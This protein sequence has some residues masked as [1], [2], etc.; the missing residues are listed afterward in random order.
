MFETN[1]AGNEV[2]CGVPRVAYCFR[3][4]PTLLGNCVSQLDTAAQ[5]RAPSSSHVLF[6]LGSR[7]APARCRAH[8]RQRRSGTGST[9]DVQA[10]AMNEPQGDAER[11][12]C[13]GARRYDAQPQIRIRE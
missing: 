8:Q 3:F 4:S 13:I 5:S 12:S 1:Q 11:H 9:R 6:V 2:K 10:A 7:A